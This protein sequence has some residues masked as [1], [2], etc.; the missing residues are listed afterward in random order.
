M[1]RAVVLLTILAAVGAASAQA[2]AD[3][4]ESAYAPSTLAKILG[5]AA[6]SQNDEAELAAPGQWYST[7]ATYTGH[8]RPPSGRYRPLANAWA[9]SRGDGTATVDMLFSGEL[10]SSNSSRVANVT[11]CWPACRAASAS[12]CTRPGR[13]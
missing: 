1:K 9:S 13:S 4:D 7:T 6:L 12:T 2:P 8:K 11:G 5:G 3:T 10:P